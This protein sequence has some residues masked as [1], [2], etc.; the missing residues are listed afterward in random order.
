M[1]F[2][3]DD[4][5]DGHDA[6]DRLQQL[7]AI[8][9]DFRCTLFAIPGRCTP[10]WCES[11]P[12]WVEL[13][14]HGWLHESNYECAAWT[15]EDMERCLDQ[16]ISRYFV[17]GFKAP[18]WQI[19]DACYE[20]LME[21]GWWVADQHLED[22]RRPAGLR[23]YF[24]ED[25]NWHGHID[26]VCGNGIEETWPQVVE[27]VTNAENFRF[28]S[29]A[30]GVGADPVDSGAGPDAAGMPPVRPVA[31]GHLLGASRGRRRAP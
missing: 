15:R 1:T 10:A 25:G 27:A 31:D 26:N 18:G 4:A 14:V 12:D 29:D 5:Y 3:W 28:A 24:Y 21:R 16:P 9:P 13:A 2:D 20:V 22:A 30:A 19:S 6:L 7:H 23:I 8:R 11:L 17:D